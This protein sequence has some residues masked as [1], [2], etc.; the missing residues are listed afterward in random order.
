MKLNSYWP[1]QRT[2]KCRYCHNLEWRGRYVS[3]EN[4]IGG[5]L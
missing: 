5:L 2:M 4:E 1:I 3:I